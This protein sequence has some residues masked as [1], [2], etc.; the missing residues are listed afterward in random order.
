MKRAELNGSSPTND[1]IQSAVNSTVDK[2]DAKDSAFEF[3][4]IACCVCGSDCPRVMGWR[5]GSSHHSQSGVR[6]KIV[7]CRKCSHIYP[8]P[9]PFPAKGL[10]DIYI[11]PDN[12]FIHHD[13]EEKKRMGG[14]I[15]RQAE[16]TL[17][18]RGRHLDV[19]CG[20]GEMLW[21][22]REAGWE[23]EGVDSSSAYLE[24]GRRNLG[25]EGRLGTLEEAHFPDEHFDLITMGGL[26][27]HLYEP[28][29][30]LCEVHRILKP[31]G[32][33]WFDAPN[34]DALYTRFGNLY[35]RVLG[36]DW[37][38]NLA[39]T[40]SPFHVQGFNLRS[41]R[42]L[43]ARV[44]FEIEQLDVGGNICPLTGMRASLR[45]RIEF[46][47]AQL[48]NWVGTHCG[49]AIYMNIWTKKPRR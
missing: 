9:M 41:V 45:K 31:G 46:R 15:L 18:H 28:Y 26:I 21:A 5:G 19:G 4:D 20:R 33:F 47:A 36:R 22:A 24:W 25:V 34:E 39:P 40:F 13:L 38:V 1:P 29:R 37:V 43:V 17:G 32:V 44:G 16:K 30:T 7:R 11:D 8:N 23:Y 2:A 27:E 48:I 14:E 12:F 49:A 10:D 42:Q 6:T 3:Q 35:M